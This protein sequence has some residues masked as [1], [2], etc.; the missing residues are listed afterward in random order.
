MGGVAMTD[1]ADN[2]AREIPDWVKKLADDAAILYSKP[3]NGLIEKYEQALRERDER[4]A[5]LEA[6]IGGLKAVFNSAKN[7][8]KFQEDTVKEL[9]AENKR[10]REALEKV[11][12]IGEDRNDNVFRKGYGKS[13]AWWQRNIEK[14]AKQALARTKESEK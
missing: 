5:K 12:E 9:V 14:V 4:I 7:E 8:I 10:L 11:L 1:K 13:W 2:E 6:E 3:V